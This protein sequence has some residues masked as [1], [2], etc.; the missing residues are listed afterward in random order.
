VNKRPERIKIIS[1][2]FTIEY[3][4]EGEG[5][6]DVDHAG[7]C[8]TMEQRILIEEGQ[9]PDTQKDTVFHEVLHAI[10]DEMGLELT[11]EQ[12]SGG[13]KG[14]LAVLMDNPSFARYLLRK[15]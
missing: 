6:L 5:E 13:A 12:V 14:V 3:V 11:E 15:A 10:S 8:R 1:K 2:R 9:K 7:E 4:K